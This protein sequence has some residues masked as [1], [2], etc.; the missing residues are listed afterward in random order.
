MSPGRAGMCARQSIDLA[1][2]LES[3]GCLGWGSGFDFP[4]LA[5][6]HALCWGTDRKPSI[7]EDGDMIGRDH[8]LY[9]VDRRAR[10]HRC[11][12]K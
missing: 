12:P 8:P 5:S 10:R 7:C 4:H 11:C 9:S 1:S 2:W 6:A 3:P